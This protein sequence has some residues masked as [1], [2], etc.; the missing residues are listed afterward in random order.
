MRS[1]Q[2]PKASLRADGKAANGFYSE[3]DGIHATAHIHPTAI[4]EQKVI[5]G[6]RTVV[7]DHVHIR[8]STRLGEECLVGEKTH[9]SYGVNIGNLQ[10][11]R[12]SEPDEN[13]LPTLVRQGATLGAGCVIGSNL[14]I[15]R[16]AMV[17]MGTLVTKSVPD[18][19]LAAGHPARSIGAVCRCGQVL[20]RFLEDPE[21]MVFHE[22][23][24]GACG[25]KYV[26][27]DGVVIEVSQQY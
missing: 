22:N 10:Q 11:L 8:H 7:W 1:E 25:L 16:F 18:F 19:H 15:G 14:Q 13:T 21:G 9:I 24:C 4:I 3:A 26:I 5:I 23:K 6:A 20:V 2:N 12:P 27:D 17:G